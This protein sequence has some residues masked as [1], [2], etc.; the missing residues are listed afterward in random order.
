[1]VTMVVVEA[2]GLVI[3]SMTVIKKREG[4]LQHI[5][6]DYRNGWSDSAVSGGKIK[7]QLQEMSLTL[8][9]MTKKFH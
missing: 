6:F 3:L 1:M 9:S 5:C 4:G 2:H 8:V 7:A